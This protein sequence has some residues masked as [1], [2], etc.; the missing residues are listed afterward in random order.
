MTYSHW[1]S[2][3]ELNFKKRPNSFIYRLDLKT[4]WSF[5]NKIKY[6][7]CTCWC[8]L[9]MFSRCRLCNGLKCIDWMLN[10]VHD[11]SPQF[12]YYFVAFIALRNV[13]WE[14]RGIDPTLSFIACSVQAW[15]KMCYNKC[16]SKIDIKTIY[17]I[18]INILTYANLW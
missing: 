11:I 2:L 12:L 14:Y 9:T 16:V 6:N 18:S 7:N 15:S 13:L 17:F 3:T 8:L 1:H 4:S 5:S 10:K